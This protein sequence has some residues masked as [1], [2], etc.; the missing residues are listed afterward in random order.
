MGRRVSAG[1]SSMLI[2]QADQAHS[3]A[4]NMTILKLRPVS[5]PNGD[6]ASTWFDDEELLWDDERLHKPQPLLATWQV[7]TLRLLKPTPTP[8]LFNPNALAVS[9]EVRLSLAHFPEIEFLPIE[10]IGFGTFF[11]VHVT[12]TL[13]LPDGSSVRRSPVSKNIVE[14]FAFPKSYVPSADFFRVAQPDDS[15]AGISGFCMSTIY[16]S[17]AGARAILATTKGYL[18]RR[19]Q[20]LTRV[21]VEGF[22]AA[23]VRDCPSRRFARRGLR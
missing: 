22:P 11:V 2:S 15:A 19:A 10:V 18:Y 9:D 7:P 1:Y 12:R 6:F 17:T 8:V 5:L 13:P 21:A 16:V 4:V 3:S 20:S 23:L 14:L